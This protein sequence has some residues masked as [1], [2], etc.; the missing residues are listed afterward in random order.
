MQSARLRRWHKGKTR[1]ELREQ[2]RQRL[3]AVGRQ[4]FAEK[5]L[6]AAN[7]TE[8]ILHP[9]GVSVGSFYHQ[10]TDKTDLFLA[11]V[12]EQSESLRGLVHAVVTLVPDRPAAEVARD[13]FATLLTVVER[14]GDVFRMMAREAESHDPRV[15]ASLRENHA[16][17][18]K[19]LAQD[20]IGSKLIPVD[21]PDVAE[22]LAELVLTLTMGAVRR[23]LDWSAAERAQWRE[24]WLRELVC[25]CLGGMRSW[26][27]AFAPEAGK[28]R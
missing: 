3:L 5:G 11:I 1:G 16:A 22:R 13:A 17:W 9:A 10:F 18:V 6:A 2:T 28:R 19:A 4:V 21:R 24:R 23:Y 25:F 15:R 8:D 27:G 26:L 20:Y 7:L 14:D 12:R